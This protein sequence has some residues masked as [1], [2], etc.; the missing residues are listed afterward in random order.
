MSWE[1][2]ALLTIYNALYKAKYGKIVFVF[3]SLR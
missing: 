1:V 3:Y 2:T